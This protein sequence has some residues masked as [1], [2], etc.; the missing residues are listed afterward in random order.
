M[1]KKRVTLQSIKC[2]DCHFE[3]PQK[4]WNVRI[5]FAIIV[6]IMMYFVFYVSN[7]CKDS[8]LFLPFLAFICFIGIANRFVCS[9]CK[10]REFLT[11]VLS[12]GS[13]KRIRCLSKTIFCLW[14]FIFVF[15]IWYMLKETFPIFCGNKMSL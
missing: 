12:D 9:Q 3:G 5:F 8:G 6:F 1:E 4:K 15:F 14:F 13:Q 10:K 2:S 11:K 7:N